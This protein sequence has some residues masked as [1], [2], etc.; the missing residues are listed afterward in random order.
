MKQEEKHALVNDEQ[1]EAYI[2]GC[3]LIDNTTY[4]RVSQYLDEDCFYTQN[5]KAIWTVVSKMVKDGIPIDL[6]SVSSELMKIPN[7]DVGIEVLIDIT[8]RTATSANA[9]YHAIRLKDL[10]RRRKIFE[11]GLLATKAGLSEEI[12]TLEIHK[13]V[14]EIFN[15][16]FEHVDGVSTLSD[17]IDSLNDIITKNLSHSGSVTGTPTGFDVYDSKS[18]GL[19]KSDLI[20]V[21]GET[22]QGK[23][24]LA[25]TMTHNAL[26]LDAKIAFY[27][28]EMTKEQLVARIL[29]AMTGIAANS[30]LYSGNL[31]SHDI[32]LLDVARGELK[33]KHLYFDDRSTSNLDSI[34]MS[35]RTLKMQVDIDGVVVDYLQILSVNTKGGVS[36]EQIMGEAARR[37]KNLAKELNIWVIAL[38]Q[39]SRDNNSPEPTLNRLRDSGQI[40][41]AADVVMLVYR[42]EYYNRCYPS[43][44]DNM[45]EFPTAGTAMVDVAKGR[46]IGVF[47]FF[48]GF[49]K[50]TASFFKSDKFQITKNIDLEEPL[51]QDAPF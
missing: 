48:L 28:M 40:A 34:L 18:G 20:I 25:L 39:L 8:N 51:E 32:A 35:I 50:D 12:P 4:N 9:E 19:Q 2:I 37:L 31:S 6:I 3:L 27:S 17:A 10:S 41:E 16:I 7:Q 11:L 46:N 14:V 24:S 38:S 26:N 45:D 30:I 49:N 21:A 1:A 47:K 44:Y 22:S 23:T 5:Y 13:Q 15:G 29:S 33:D 36:R 42:P 43:P